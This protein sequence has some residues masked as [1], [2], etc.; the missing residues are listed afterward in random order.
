MKLIIGLGNPGRVYSETRHN[1][2]SS[3][4]KALAKE[5]RVSLKRG[6]FSSALS[7]KARIKGV[8]AVLAMPVLFMNLSGAAVSALVKK[9]KINLDDLLV[10]LD[11]LDLELGKL[12]LKAD[13]SCAG[14]R[15]L[16]SVIK[17][18]GSSQFCRL[19]V[20]IGRPQNSGAD[21]SN[22]V[23]SPFLKKEKEAAAQAAEKACEAIKTWV[24]EG[25]SKTMNTFN[26]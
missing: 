1:I 18:L 3:I 10:V 4:I 6:I 25:I 8:D 17:A 22:Y 13:G 2:G 20:G 16:E 21:I 7:A 12:K 15:G 11:D 19:R 9:H 26:K 5:C 24:S 23:L 14:H